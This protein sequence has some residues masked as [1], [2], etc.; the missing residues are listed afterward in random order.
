MEDGRIVRGHAR[1]MPRP[2]ASAQ[3]RR[4]DERG[5]PT[6][7]PH[8]AILPPPAFLAAP[9]PAAVLA[10]LPGAR[11]VGGCVRDAL[12]ERP[13]HDVDV[14]APL[15]PEAMVPLLRRAPG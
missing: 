4:R 10:A 13:V 7:R 12:A 14:A 1:E 5:R 9:A 6:I 2:P 8:A 3:Q 11:A 15:P